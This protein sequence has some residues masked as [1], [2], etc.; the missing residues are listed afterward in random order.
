MEGTPCGSPGKAGGAPRRA[1]CST[2]HKLEFEVHEYESGR[3]VN[4]WVIAPP[5]FV[6][7]AN[8]RR[9]GELVYDGTRSPLGVI[10]QSEGFHGRISLAEL[11]KHLFFSDD[12]P[13]AVVYTGRCS[14]VTANEVGALASPKDFTIASAT[15]LTTWTWRHARNMAR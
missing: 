6:E 15:A 1:K 11:K 3:E 9:N 8:I 4:G 2:K 14:I 12:D 13:D 10:A 7:K 5:W